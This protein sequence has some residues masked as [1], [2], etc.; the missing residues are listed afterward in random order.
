VLDGV[1]DF[2]RSRPQVP[3]RDLRQARVH[4]VAPSATRSRGWTSGSPSAGGSSVRP[5]GKPGPRRARAC[6]A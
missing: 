2:P 3:L 5:P 1:H 4:T 6:R